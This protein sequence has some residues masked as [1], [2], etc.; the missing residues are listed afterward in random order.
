MYALSEWLTAS[1]STE[2]LWRCVHTQP[3]LDPAG[4]GGPTMREYFFVAYNELEAAGC[5][6]DSAVEPTST[7]AASSEPRDGTTRTHRDIHTLTA[8]ARN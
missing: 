8:M 4:Y 7:T 1:G 6:A 5:L 3:G 2:S